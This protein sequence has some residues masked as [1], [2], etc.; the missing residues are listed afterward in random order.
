MITPKSIDYKNKIIN[1]Y[2]RAVL[3]EKLSKANILLKQSL[4]S[5]W[6][7]GWAHPNFSF[8]PQP[9]KS[10]ISMLFLAL[11]WHKGLF[12]SLQSKF[13]LFFM[14]HCIYVCLNFSI[15]IHLL[16]YKPTILCFSQKQS[17][18]LFL[19]RLMFFYSNYSETDW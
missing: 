12:S 13:F 9:L 5:F 17:C 19:V 4:F 6:L 16:Y 14:T 3:R 7:L 11:L 15:C 8:H 1:Q 10:S 2:R 18:C